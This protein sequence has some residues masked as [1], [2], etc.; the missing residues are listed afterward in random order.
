[1]QSVVCICASKV[2]TY[3][4]EMQSQGLHSLLKGGALRP[5]HLDLLPQDSRLH[6]AFS[7]LR[8][9]YFVFIY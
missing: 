2:T 9:L 4:R 8:S 1:M 6:Q 5:T 3:I 7:L